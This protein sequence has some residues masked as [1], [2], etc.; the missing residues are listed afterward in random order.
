MHLVF[1]CTGNT[2]RSPMA[3]AITRRQLALRGVKDVTVGSAGTSA[4]PD[5]PASDGALLV[6]MEHGLDLNGHRSRSVTSD[7]VATADLVLTM[8][9]QHLDRVEA[10]GGSGRAWL[11][12][13][14]AEGEQGAEGRAVSDPF[15]GDLAMYRATYR[16]LDEVIGRVLDRLLAD[17]QP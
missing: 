7:L 15:G 5:A 13:A 3:E 17:R 6:A 2:C 14:Y 11:L 4:W 16:D 9:P 8:G 1:V 12:T 10:L